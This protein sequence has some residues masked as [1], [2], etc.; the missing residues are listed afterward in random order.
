MHTTETLA[1]FPSR[2]L[3]IS[4]TFLL[5][6]IAAKA[7]GEEAPTGE[8]IYQAKCASCHGAKG[9]GKVDSY[10][11]PLVGDRSIGELTEYISK[12]MPEDKPGTCTGDEAVRVSQ[13]IHET[14]Y[15]STAQA[16]N[17]PARVELSHLTV[18]QY[19]NSVADLIG[20]FR[21][22]GS[23][24]HRV[25]LVGEYFKSRN[26]GGNDRVF[27]RIDRVV[28]FDF[29]DKSPDADNHDGTKIEP[30]EFAIKWRGSVF[31]PDTGE[32][33][34][35]V[36]TDQATRLWVNDQR[37]PLVDAYVKSGTDTEH[38]GTIFLLGGRSYPL[39]LEF[40]KAS[41]GVKDQK[42]KEKPPAKASISLEWKRPHLVGEVIPARCLSPG[43]PQEICVVSTKFPPDDRS[44]GWERATTISKEWD[45]ATTEAAIELATYIGNHLNQLSGSKPDSPERTDKLKRFCGKLA[46]IAFRRPLSDEVKQRYIDRH[47][48]SSSDPEIA[49]NRVVLLLLKSPR[50][51]YR[52][53]GSQQ[54]NGNEPYHVASR[55]S[56][57]LW[58]S[59][60]DEELLQKAARG[61]LATREQIVAQAQRMLGDRRTH[62]K[63]REFLFRWLKIDRVPVLSKD[64]ERFPDFS[65]VVANDLRTSLELFLDEILASDA[66]DFRQLLLSDSLHLNGRL[67]GF[68]GAQ[69]PPDAEFQKVSLDSNERAGVLSHPYLMTGFAYTATSSPIHRGIFVARSLLGRTLRPP[70]EAVAP[71]APQLQPDLTTRDRVALQ[72]SPEVCQSCHSMI[73]PLGFTFEH[74]DAVGR[75][76]KDENGKPIVA[77]GAYRTRSGETVQFDG[78]RDLAK[79]LAD[80]PETHAAFVEQLFHGAIKQ[81]IRAYGSQTKELLKEAF[82]RENFSI[83]KLMVEIVAASALTPVD[84]KTQTVIGTTRP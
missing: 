60:P 47:F 79:Y 67:A 58:D 19:Q 13:F 22:T 24:D 6:L 39:R 35:L 31:A 14:F 78:V 32:Y 49:C 64:L 75:F 36:R 10:A 25:G 30:Y 9:E 52:E 48:A 42:A 5:I 72:T 28:S 57:G 71:L 12:S 41:Q 18:R 34:F 76:R 2:F 33:E 53:L 27:E 65:S 46:E 11:H 15:S 43:Q 61:E 38:R 8:M 81:P 23:S 4:F 16:R 37:R 20:L 1:L 26:F 63:L 77:T 51:L 84:E 82:V 45:Q 55:L 83:R 66:S 17:K 7:F 62:S 69:L 44:F 54:A 56:F 73:N 68:Y 50:F 3:L 29:Q 74:F 59:I 80:S 70:P 21:G 40:S